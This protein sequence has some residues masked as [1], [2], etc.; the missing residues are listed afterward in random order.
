[1]PRRMVNMRY[2]IELLGEIDSYQVD[3]GFKTRTQTIIYLI[4]LGL[5]AQLKNKEERR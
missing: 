5:D 4:Q 1:M 2:P 3:K